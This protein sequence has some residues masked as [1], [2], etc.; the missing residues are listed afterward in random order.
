MSERRTRRQAAV[1][2]AADS[3]P[4]KAAPESIAEQKVLTNGNGE[5]HTHV[6]EADESSEPKENIFLFAPNL[7]GAHFSPQPLP[8]TP[9]HLWAYQITTRSRDL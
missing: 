9:N 4:T 7:I 8:H 6:V 5:A 2:A 3:T 1:A